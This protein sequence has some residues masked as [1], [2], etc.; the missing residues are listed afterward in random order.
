M[1]D[2][3]E[4]KAGCDWPARFNYGG[5]GP[6]LRSKPPLDWWR[7]QLYIAWLWLTDFVD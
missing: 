5:S 3:L 7:K 1:Q 4:D 6:Y 2:L